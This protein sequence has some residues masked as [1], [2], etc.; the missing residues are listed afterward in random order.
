MRNIT[1]EYELFKSAINEYISDLDNCRYDFNILENLKKCFDNEEESFELYK[2]FHKLI[3]YLLLRKR[4]VIIDN[5]NNLFDEIKEKFCIN[6][7][8]DNIIDVKEY[9]NSVIT[10]VIKNFSV[11]DNIIQFIN[12]LLIHNIKVELI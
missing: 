12:L 5:T 4:I 1:K 2:D 6:K 11:N 9:L 8:I 3:I 7:S 10:V